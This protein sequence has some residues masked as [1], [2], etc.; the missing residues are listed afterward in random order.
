MGLLEAIKS[1]E[2]TFCR[3][4]SQWEKVRKIS[5]PGFPFCCIWQGYVPHQKEGVLW[6]KDKDPGKNSKTIEK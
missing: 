1:I 2:N 3:K 5:L 4:S 6:E